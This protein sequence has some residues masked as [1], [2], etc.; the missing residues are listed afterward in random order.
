MS[1]TKHTFE[2]LIQYTHRLENENKALKESRDEL[3]EALQLAF[4]YLQDLDPQ[5]KE[6]FLFKI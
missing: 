1:E 2:K 6:N 3:L 4:D 5:P